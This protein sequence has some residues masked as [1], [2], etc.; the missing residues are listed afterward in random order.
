[1]G[2]CGGGQLLHWLDKVRVL[3]QELSLLETLISDSQVGFHPLPFAVRWSCC[4]HIGRRPALTQLHGIL[5]PIVPSLYDGRLATHLVDEGLGPI[6]GR[7]VSDVGAVAVPVHAGEALGRAL[8]RS[9]WTG[10]TGLQAARGGA[11]RAGRALLREGRVREGGV[12]SHG[13][14]R[15]AAHGYM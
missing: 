8:G 10:R 6:V 5:R 13:P 1:M 11:V 2:N 3:N 4:L 14:Q 12:V 15:H 9:G 7:P